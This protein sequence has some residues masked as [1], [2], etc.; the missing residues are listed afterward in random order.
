MTE[1]ANKPDIGSILADLELLHDFVDNFKTIINEADSESRE[2]QLYQLA[3]NFS[4][5]DIGKM[6]A[7]LS[8]IE[9]DFSASKDNNWVEEQF[10][11]LKAEL[12]SKDQKIQEFKL[13]LADT[14]IESKSIQKRSAEQQETIVKLRNEI[15]QMQL[16]T[17]DLSLKLATAEKN[18]QATQTELATANEELLEL[19]ER[20]YALKGRSA[21]LEDQIRAFDVQIQELTRTNL[22]K[23][24]EIDRLSKLSE[25]LDSSFELTRTQR[26]ALEER[27]NELEATI[28][29][30]QREKNIV[31][32]RLD[33]LLTGLPRSVSYANPRPP[34]LEESLL[35]PRGFLPYLPFCFPERVPH[36]ISFRREVKHSFAKNFPRENPPPV[37]IFPHDFKVR[38]DGGNVRSFAFKPVFHCSITDEFTQALPPPVPDAQISADRGD[39]YFC[40]KDFFPVLVEA[41]LQAA[42]HK[43]QQILVRSSVLKP[44]RK[45]EMLNKPEFGIHT[46]SLDL[47]LSF[48]TRNIIESNYRELR[49]AEPLIT[50]EA[51]FINKDGAIKTAN[52]F[53]EK[54]AFRY[55]YQLKSHK[56]NLHRVNFAQSF[57]RGAGLRSVL[58]T[59]GNTINSMVQKYDVF[60]SSKPG[61][62]TKE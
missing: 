12:A 23:D 47:L 51:T 44:A 60:S 16:H 24:K 48:L 62:N 54:L 41:E 38:F 50:G 53:N 34:E 58:E 19:R 45:L 17:K 27:S 29:T 43:P 7:E 30:L 3:I 35:E 31:Q 57:R 14:V 49:H 42:L 26:N 8:L 21:D 10:A 6:I 1:N 18:F 46:Y 25:R 39:F 55:G 36:V 59:F 22:E 28:E 40:A 9:S 32:G 20:S 61:K 11:E 2:D 15:A 4:G 5:I 13:S 52:I 33:K 37:P 56:L